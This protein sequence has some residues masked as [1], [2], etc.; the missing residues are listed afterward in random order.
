MKSQ[1]YN[2]CS[3]NMDEDIPKY[4]DTSV[5]FFRKMRWTESKKL[6]LK[7]HGHAVVSYK[8]LVYCIGGK[9]D[10]K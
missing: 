6:P 4:N 7:I 2:Q 8:G 5:A 1:C 9:T 10:D 3:I